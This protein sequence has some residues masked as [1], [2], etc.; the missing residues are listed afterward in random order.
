MKKIEVDVLFKWTIVLGTVFLLF[1]CTQGAGNADNAMK[2]LAKTLPVSADAQFQNLNTFP[3]D[4]TCG[5]YNTKG[6]YRTYEGFR[7]F[8]VRNEQADKIASDDDW[9]IFC[10]RD[11]AARIQARFGIDLIDG[12]NRTVATIQQQLNALVN[13]LD[14]YLADNATLPVTEQGLAALAEKSTT[15]PV[16]GNFRAG[17]YLEQIPV[18][19]WGRPYQYIYEEQLRTEP[20]K[21]SLYTL[22]KDN[23]EGGK[24]ENAD[25]SIDHLT[26]LNHLSNL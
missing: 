22:G 2:V 23:T 8:I 14:A 26:Y 3:G 4:V 12:E 9:D 6:E 19:P 1:G 7:R 21:Y 10:N 15:S 11:P 17:G 5:E 20:I 18:D 13:A 16:P 25:I 24:G